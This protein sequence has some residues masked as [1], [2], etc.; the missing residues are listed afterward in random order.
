M[1]KECDQCP[2]MHVIFCGGEDVGTVS[3]GSDDQRVGSPPTDAALKGGEGFRGFEGLSRCKMVICGFQDGASC[4]LP[5]SLYPSE[6]RRVERR[7]RSGGARS[8]G[9]RLSRGVRRG[10]DGIVVDADLPQLFHCPIWPQKCRCLTTPPGKYIHE[11][12]GVSEGVS[13][14]RA[15]CL[16]KICQLRSA[17]CLQGK[18]SR[19]GLKLISGHCAISVVL[20]GFQTHS[21]LSFCSPKCILQQIGS[22]RDFPGR[23]RVSYLR[24]GRPRSG[25]RRGL[26]GREMRT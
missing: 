6:R 3:E 13:R 11:R 23:R 1:P 18:V 12:L 2:Q 16:R 9:L 26:Y 25:Y 22:L 21:A 20:D 4:S 24:F 8:S 14:R 17:L 7:Y 5:L 10:K 19:E 15:C